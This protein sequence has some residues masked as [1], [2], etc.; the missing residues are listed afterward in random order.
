MGLADT[1]TKPLSRSQRRRREDIVQAALQIF[2]R[3]G[4]EAAKM[5][6]IAREAEVAKGT[7]YLYFDTKNAL[8]E[9]VILTAI[10]PTLQKMEQ[11]AAESTGTA[12]ELLSQQLLIAAKRMASPEMASLL[13]HM[14][15]AGPHHK[16]IAKLYYDKVVQSGLEHVGATLQRGVESGEFRSEVEQIDPLVLVGAHIYTTV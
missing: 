14:I 10:M 16:G 4:F 7:L 12:R 3:D 11:V 1:E 6:D 13:R 2:D 5:E 15:S 9:A 8:L